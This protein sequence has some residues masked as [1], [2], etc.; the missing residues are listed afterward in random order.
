VDGGVL[1]LHLGG[2]VLG[3]AVPG[4]GEKRPQKQP[5][6]RRRP[7]AGGRR[8]SITPAT[9]SSTVPSPSPSL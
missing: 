8:R 5:P 2:E 1:H 4:R 9:D 7:P 3:G 6:G